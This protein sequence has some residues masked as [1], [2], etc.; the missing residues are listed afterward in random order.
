MT[1]A[2]TRLAPAARTA[3]PSSKIHAGVTLLEFDRESASGS[4]RRQAPLSASSQTERAA[5]SS[6]TIEI[7]TSAPAARS[8]MTSAPSINCHVSRAQFPGQFTFAQNN[9]VSAQRHEFDNQHKPGHGRR[10]STA[11]LLNAL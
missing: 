3:A 4:I 10:I 8:A 11:G 7:A 2:S 5:L 9:S 1:C 6:E